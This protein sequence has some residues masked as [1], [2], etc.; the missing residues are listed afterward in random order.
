M[1]G[2]KS[3]LEE[4]ETTFDNSIGPS[5]NSDKKVKSNKPVISNKRTSSAR[6]IYNQ[7]DNL[8]ELAHELKTTAKTNLDPIINM[9]EQRIPIDETDN[10]T[11]RF[12]LTPLFVTYSE[13]I[14]DIYK[15]LQQTLDIVEST[16]VLLD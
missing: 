2:K 10:V 14:T 12:K 13:V 15:L 3:P 6:V 5:I 16:E 4:I 9:E 11:E 7:L 8:R 1:S